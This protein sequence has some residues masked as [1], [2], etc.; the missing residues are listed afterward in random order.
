[1]KRFVIVY[2]DITYRIKGC[3]VKDLFKFSRR[4]V[5]EIPASFESVDE[6]NEWLDELETELA[7]EFIEKDIDYYKDVNTYIKNIVRL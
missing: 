6:V 5:K 7:K 1:M 4:E 3:A 2:Y